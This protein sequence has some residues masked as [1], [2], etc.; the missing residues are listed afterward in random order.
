MKSSFQHILWIGFFMSQ[1]EH[2]TSQTT[3]IDR[4]DTR[5]SLLLRKD[6]KEIRHMD[7][8]NDIEIPYAAKSTYISREETPQKCVSCVS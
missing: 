8:N 6:N 5:I 3:I 1:V 2:S 4:I 7:V